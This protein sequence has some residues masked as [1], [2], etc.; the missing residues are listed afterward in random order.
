MSNAC[1]E[2]NTEVKE[3]IVT[4][5][6]VK[7]LIEIRRDDGKITMSDS[8][9]YAEYVI[10]GVT[11]RPTEH[12]INRFAE[13]TIEVGRTLH[14]DQITSC[15]T[16]LVDSAWVLNENLVRAKA[17][18]DKREVPAFY[19]ANKKIIIS[20]EVVSGVCELITVYCAK[21]SRWYQTWLAITEKHIRERWSNCTALKTALAKKAKLR[22]VK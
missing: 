21:E 17:I 3:Q 9:V 22:L 10:N 1:N 16:E 20:F 12:F 5:A 14:R 11:F 19:L 2:L 7:G 4:P 18:V 15:L 8:S 6:P 13:R